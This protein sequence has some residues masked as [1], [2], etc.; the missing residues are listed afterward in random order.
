MEVPEK[1]PRT[2]TRPKA[3]LINQLGQTQLPVAKSNIHVITIVGQVE[4]HLVMPPKIKPQSMNI[5][6][7]NWLQWSEPRNRRAFSHPKY[8]WGDVEAG[9]AIAE[10]IKSLSK[11]TVSLVLGGDTVLVCLLLF[12]PITLLLPIPLP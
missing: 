3:E 10:M 6:F 12:L 1:E 5:L 9:L 8:S 7:L 11:P 4:G 2:G